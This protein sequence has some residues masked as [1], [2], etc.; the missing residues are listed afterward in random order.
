MS[1]T[2]CTLVLIHGLIGSLDYFDPAGRIARADVRTCDLLGYGSRRE[3]SEARLSLSAQ[4]DHV[5]GFIA[6]LP[7]TPVW[8]LGHSM[9]GA[10]AML[11]ARRRRDLLSG[12]INVE[13]NFTLED[14]FWSG[15][16]IKQGIEEWEREYRAMQADVSG[17]LKRCGVAP[18]PEHTHLARQILEW[19]SA[20]TVYA[21]SQA[22][23]EET[24][25]P[26]YTKE[27]RGVIEP[28]LP[29]H[30]IAGARSAAGWDVP[31]FVRAAARSYT[32]LPGTGH[33]MML[34]DPEGFCRIVDRILPEAN[35]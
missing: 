21:M 10:I 22:L 34:E 20:R 35:R 6:S 5:S 18:D 2:R 30:L 28:G 24:G 14:A 7:E 32:E 3:L 11:V 23:V 19:Q 26:S 16:I 27:V 31:G 8:L 13:G 12:V 1:S 9:G 15:R 29:I 25:D 33:L 4:V 17:W